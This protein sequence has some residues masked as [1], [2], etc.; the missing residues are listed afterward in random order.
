MTLIDVRIFFVV[1]SSLL[2]I[3]ASVSM[4]KKLLC[5]ARQN[6]MRSVLGRC[7]KGVSVIDVKKSVFGRCKQGVILVDVRILFVLIRDHL[8]MPIKVR[9]QRKVLCR[10]MQRLE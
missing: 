3:P 7:E 8:Q 4:Q 10:V 2:L 6:L 5:H 9:M 1:I